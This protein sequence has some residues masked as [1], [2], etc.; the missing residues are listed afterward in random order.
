M[1]ALWSYDLAAALGASRGLASRPSWYFWGPARFVQGGGKGG[2]LSQRFA[3]PAPMPPPRFCKPLPRPCGAALG[4][5]TG[6]V[7]ARRQGAVACPSDL[8]RSEGCGKDARRCSA[9]NASSAR[10]SA[11]GERGGSVCACGRAVWRCPRHGVGSRGGDGGRCVARYRRLSRSDPA[12]RT[13]GAFGRR[14]V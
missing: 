1:V 4:A 3:M 2:S 9:S 12:R 14:Q 7:M 10:P 5:A 6:T 11:K 13:R 8:R